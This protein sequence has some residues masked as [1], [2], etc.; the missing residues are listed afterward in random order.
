MIINNKRG[1]RRPK[2]AAELDRR[3][4]CC[5]RWTMPRQAVLDLLGR[6]PRHWSAKEIHRSLRGACPGIGLMTVYRTLDLLERTGVVHKIAAAGG[7]AHF[8]LRPGE[9]KDHHHHLV[10]T[11]CGRIV[12]YNDFVREELELVR[13]TERSLARRHG[14]LIQDHNIEFLGLCRACQDRKA[15][16]GPGKAPSSTNTRIGRKDEP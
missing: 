1:L 10:C 3:G 14:F 7:P 8:E 15:L 12:D 11:V 9:K 6:K 5:A 4:G 13:K 16:T 2:T